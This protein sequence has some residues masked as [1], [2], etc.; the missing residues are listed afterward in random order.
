MFDEDER[1][2]NSTL[3]TEQSEVGGTVL[4]EYDEHELQPEYTLHYLASRDVFQAHAALLDN[5]IVSLREQPDIYRLVRTHFPTLQQWHEKHTGWRIQRHSTFFR[6]ER[7]LHTALPVFLDDKLKR[8]RDFTCLAWLLW[9]A[10]K[11]YLAGG[12]RN[13]QFLLSQLIEEVQSQSQ[14]AEGA[15]LD[16]RN[17]QDRYSMWRALDYLTRLD[18]LKTF[19]GEVRRWAEDEQQADSEVLYEFTPIAHS[20]I[21][22]FNEQHLLLIMANPPTINDKPQVGLVMSNPSATNDQQD[23]SNTNAQKIA[24]SHYP[25]ALVRAWRTL[26]LGPAFFRIDDPE[27]FTALSAHVEQVSTELS[28]SFGWLLEFNRDYACIVRGDTL[29]AG[30]GPAFTLNSAFDQ[31]ALLLC[32]AFRTQ[33]EQGQ[34][35]PDAYGCINVS[36]R[37]ILPLF[38]EIRTRYGANW[39]VTVKKSDTLDLL[40][41][42]FERMRQ[43]GILRGPDSDENVLI[44]PTAARYNVGYEQKVTSS[45]SSTSAPARSKKKGSSTGKG[46]QQALE[47]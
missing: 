22:A 3:F 27:A 14:E 11:R 39:G 19:E 40:N 42:V 18:G 4:E 26:L 20:L 28:R 5:T 15:P 8:A 1:L 25:P 13:Q 23:I 6:L 21:E 2:D 46:P 30:S 24:Q 45:S 31:M 7:H 34:W 37:D 9:F 41:D 33:V 38:H 36:S 32:S 47:W 17:Q 43:Y 10:E 12:G 44:L 29:S 35:E 16:F